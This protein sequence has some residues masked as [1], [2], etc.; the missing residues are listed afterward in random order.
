MSVFLGLPQIGAEPVEP[1]QRL[2]HALD[3]ISAVVHIHTQLFRCGSFI[4]ALTFYENFLDIAR[5]SRFVL[6]AASVWST[7]LFICL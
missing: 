4:I 2:C 6:R 3:P 5:E 1:L 7:I